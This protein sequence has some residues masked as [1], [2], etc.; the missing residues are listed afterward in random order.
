MRVALDSNVMIYAEGLDAPEKRDRVL[1]IVNNIPVENILVPIQTIGETTRWLMSR[2]KLTRQQAAERATRWLTYPTQD[3]NRQ[4]VEA[5]LDLM[6]QHQLQYWDSIIVAAA[7][8][9]QATVPLPEDTQDGFRWRGVTIMDP[10]AKKLRPALR[11]LLSSTS[12]EA[13]P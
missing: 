7:A 13:P 10:F 6:A 8:E 3:T 2:G 9:A 1:D 12:D 11:K 4:V 5:A